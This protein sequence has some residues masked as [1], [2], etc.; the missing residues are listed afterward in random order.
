M[1]QTSRLAVALCTFQG[2]RYLGEQLA[3]ISAQTLAPDAV[4]VCDDGSTDA[5]LEMVKTFAASAPFPVTVLG[6][7]GHR[8]GPAANFERALRAAHGDILVLCDQDDVWLPHRLERTKEVL[9]SR[10]DAAAMFSDAQLIDEASSPTGETLWEALG[11][12]GRTQDRFTSGAPRERVKVLC[13][14]N[15][16]TG[17]TL[18]IRSSVRGYT[19]PIPEG[20]MHDH[21]IALMAAACDEVVMWPEVLCRY[22]VHDRQHTGIGTRRPP[23]WYFARRRGQVRRRLNKN[24]RDLLVQ[25]SEGLDLIAGRLRAAAG[26]DP[27]VVAFVE[28]RRDHYRARGALRHG[29][30][31]SKIV[32][33]ELASGRYHRHSSGLSSVAK[34]LLLRDVRQPAE[35]R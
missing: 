21:W 31:R 3:S 30:G 12:T 26:A 33:R 5:T 18:A 9:E 2:E 32:V 14:G 15:V 34:D 22:R 20:W 11:I 10:P 4:V 27:A 17:A 24:E 23:P 1:A 8:L 25:Q 29:A 19:L 13:E 28:S 35:G 7:D 16:V 6:S